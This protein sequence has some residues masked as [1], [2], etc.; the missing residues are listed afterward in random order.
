VKAQVGNASL[1]GVVSDQTG[2]VIPNAD[3][4]IR[5]ADEVFTRSTVSGANGAYVIPTLPPG[6]Y[7]LVVS[8]NGFTTQQTL[9]FALSSGQTEALD[10]KLE[11]ASSNTKVIVSAAP[12]LLQTT[13]ESLETVLSEREMNSAPLLGRSFLNAISLDPGV[14]PV[15]PAGSTTSHSAV[16]QST[17]P[18]V[19]GQR[20]KDN[21]F[22][23]DGVENTDPNLLGVAVYPP[24]DAISE[25]TVDSG[26]G[27]SAFGHASGATVDIVTKSGT[28]AVHGDAWEYWRNNILDARSYFQ[29]S[30]GSYHWNQF[31]FALGGPLVIPHLVPADKHWYLYG[32]YE[33]V[34]ITSPAD[35]T[36]LVPTKAQ[37]SGDFSGNAPVYNPFSTT[38]TAG[39]KTRQQFSNN[40]IPTNLLNPTALALA[41]ALFP[42]PNLAPDA[43]PGANFINQA[44]NSTH[45]NQWSVRGDH[46][47]GAKDSFF[48][49]YSSV[50]NLA[51]GAGLPKVLGT[52][53]D[54]LLNAEASD[55]HIFSNSMVLTLRYG[56]TRVNYFTGNAYPADLAQSSGLGAVFPPSLGSDIIP[57]IGINGYVGIPGN[58]S[59][60][61]PLYEHSGIVDAQKIVGG[62]AF[63]FG[64]DIVH[65]STATDNLTG[66]S[67]SFLTTQTSDFD[68]KTGDALASFLLGVPD[69]AAR[70][71]GGH[72]AALDTYGYGFYVQDTWRHGP[73]TINGGVRYDYNAPPVNRFGLGGLDYGTGI[74]VWDRKN[75]VTGEPA[76]IRRG[77]IPPDRNNFA[78]RL[79]FAYQLSPR[80]V[81]RASAGVFFDSFGS[82]YIQASGSAQ[83]NWPFAY[84]QSVSGLN[85]TT[86]TAQLPNP[87][88]GNPVGSTKPPSA[89]SQCLNV[90]KNSSRTPYV[91]EWTLSLQRQIG[92][93][94]T[95]EGAYFGSKATKLGAQIV[96]NT[97]T[98]PGPAP[99]SSR[100]IYPQY[101]PYILNGYNEFPSWYE[102]ASLRVQRRYSRGLSFLLAYTYS[103]NID[104]VD[105]L[106]NGGY[107]G[108]VTSNP[109][110]YSG[111]IN[112]GL[113]GFDMRNVISLSNV[114]NIP[115]RSRYALIN[116]VA[117]GW[118][119]SDIFSYHS[120][121]P[122]S[123]FLGN[124]NENIGTAGRSTEYANV[125]GDPKAV[126]K[127]PQEWFNTAA[128]AAP[129][130]GTIGNEHR[131]M[132]GL[133]SG[134]LVDDDLAA[135][136]I[137]PIHDSVSF[138]LRGEFFNLFN[139]TNFGFPG[140]VFGTKQFGTVSNTLNGGRTI[141][142]AGKIHF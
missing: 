17:E 53:T 24:P 44:G 102:G 52:T 40:Q 92:E 103:K 9:P 57:P 73:L 15:P 22:L 109:T 119:L 4:E 26:V 12:P 1:T 54:H 87:F 72:A 76:N 14:V 100:Q 107:F 66:T 31:G 3:V 34:R 32:Y 20:Q 51:S 134:G 99:Y 93:N 98:S 5:G 125:V 67:I 101:S 117:A 69:S 111:D 65:T 131:N 79:G 58:R 49:R 10:I 105:N 123:V 127:T 129:A 132:A 95:V 11:I 124:D 75:P 104:Y 141:Q 36:A 68:S 81:V 137:W 77:G 83:G 136:K 80:T 142:L 21:S 110:R 122:F 56:L 135:G 27:S 133:D 18:S 106:S 108:Q 43:I 78:P 88:P 33:G 138:E 82:N 89:C 37:L 6:R 13:S 7:L 116:A 38:Q 130:V 126:H 16:S 41:K 86:V 70:Q 62:H 25:M 2:A 50:S 64:G 60:V 30:V 45:G 112:R 61:G 39:V 29:P 128:F 19:Y 71:V 84:P 35:F 118:E 90:D 97:A 91:T 48:A 55:T 28:S 113:A 114:W 115:W 85:A 47:F 96:D 46:Q 140:Q 94:L 63:E 139:H 42:A 74:Y 59:V 120:G 23:L 8:A 121:M